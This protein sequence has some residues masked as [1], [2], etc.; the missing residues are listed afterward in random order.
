M[1]YVGGEIVTE[2]VLCKYEK[3]S[4]IIITSFEASARESK[5]NENKIGEC[6]QGY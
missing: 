6:V 1:I 2:S 3:S 4:F 5:R